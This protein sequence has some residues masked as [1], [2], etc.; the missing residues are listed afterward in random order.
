M[1]ARVIIGCL[2]FRGFCF[3]TSWSTAS[4][5]SDCAGGP[6]IMMLIHKICIAFNGFGI[7]IKVLRAEQKKN[8]LAK[9]APRCNRYK[10]TYRSK[11]MPQ[12]MCSVEIVQSFE[13]CKKSIYPLQSPS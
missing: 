12:L 8:S 10:A 13:C 7:P 2:T 6:S 5:P 3:R 9:K 11:I 1:T 4:T